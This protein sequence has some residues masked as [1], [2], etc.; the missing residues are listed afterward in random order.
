MSGSVRAL[1][2]GVNGP[3]VETQHR[4]V[5][6]IRSRRSRSAVAVPGAGIDF[7]VGDGSEVLCRVAVVVEA[8]KVEITDQEGIDARLFLRVQI[9]PADAA[10]DALIA[11]AVES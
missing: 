3:A 1:R 9:L 6:D 4:V 11:L 5:S 2:G 8:Y 7:R 10:L